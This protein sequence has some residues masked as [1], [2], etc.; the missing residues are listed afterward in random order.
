MVFTSGGCQCCYLVLTSSAATE[1]VSA[2][3]AST[4]SDRFVG[5]V[6]LGPLLGIDCEGLNVVVLTESGTVALVW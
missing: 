2:E 1:H 4:P 5:L 6:H 3:S